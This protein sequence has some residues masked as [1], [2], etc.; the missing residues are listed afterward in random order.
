LEVAAPESAAA[1]AQTVRQLNSPIRAYNHHR[2][3]FMRL[4]QAMLVLTL[5]L[6]QQSVWSTLPRNGP[7][8]PTS[9]L[10][11]QTGVYRIYLPLVIKAKPPKY[12]RV[13][14]VSHADQFAHGRSGDYPNYGTGC[15]CNDCTN[16]ASQ[17]L[18][19]GTYPLREGNWNANSPF[20]WWYKKVMWWYENSKTWSATDWLNT[21]I[22]QYRPEEFDVSAGTMSTVDISELAGGD[23]IIMDTR[24]NDE[25]EGPPDG[26]PDH[27]RIIVGYGLTSSN[28]E[29]YGC[30]ENPTV[31]SPIYT[32]LANQHCVDRWHIA[33]NY[34]L[35]EEYGLWLIHVKW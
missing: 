29:D 24:D 23:F 32:L 28:L 26:I 1:E 15:S 6:G 20:E 27:V 16:Y 34:N 22:H 13:A 18:H 14:A 19:K 3:S 4:V 7:D 9:A 21:Y 17:V 30:R 12:N 5:T 10:N 35:T 25:E 31:P 11:Y 33:W 2:S 8:A